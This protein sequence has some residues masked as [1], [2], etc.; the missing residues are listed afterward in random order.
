MINKSIIEKKRGD[1]V[2]KIILF[3]L[4]VFGLSAEGADYNN[5]KALIFDAGNAIGKTVSINGIVRGIDMMQDWNY[6]RRPYIR[7]KDVENK[8]GHSLYI[9]FNSRF[10]ERIKKLKDDQLIRVT[11]RIKELGM[12]TRCDLVDFNFIQE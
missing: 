11:C 6:Q 2:K 12:L 7:V 5:M 1:S 3:F 10:N 4:I 8:N 9:F